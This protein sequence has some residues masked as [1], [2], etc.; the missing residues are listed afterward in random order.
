MNMT[1]L[2]QGLAESSL[3]KFQVTSSDNFRTLTP[4]GMVDRVVG[5]HA[6]TTIQLGYL[7][8]S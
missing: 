6:V 8:I 7:V 4:S 2:N 5:L 3:N 1:K